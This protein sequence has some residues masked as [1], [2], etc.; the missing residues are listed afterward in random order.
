MSSSKALF[1]T[2]D[3]GAKIGLTITDCATGVA[4]DV[5]AA[6]SLS[7]IFIKPSG[8]RVEQ[9]A[10]FADFGGATGDGTDGRIMYTT[11]SGFL[12]EIGTWE[13]QGH[14]V[15]LTGEFYTTRSFFEVSEGLPL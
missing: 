11:T 10:A 9:T 14:V 7:L 4:V 13:V 15:D 3:V 8:A 6:T 1:H 5:S 2:G 12:D